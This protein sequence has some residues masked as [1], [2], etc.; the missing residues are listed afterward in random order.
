M[1][2]QAQTLPQD[3]VELADQKVGE[4]ERADFLFGARGD[5]SRPS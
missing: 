5:R 2:V 3:G 4:E 1:T